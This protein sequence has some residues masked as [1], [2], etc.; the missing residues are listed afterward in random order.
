[1][2][3]SKQSPAREL[4]GV[5]NGKK[6]KV[7]SPNCLKGGVEVNNEV[8]KVKQQGRHCKRRILRKQ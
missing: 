6:Y 4:K 8:E 1:L 2:T 3:I 7:V 5:V